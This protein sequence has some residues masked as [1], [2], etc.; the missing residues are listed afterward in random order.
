MN[1]LNGQLPPD[2]DFDEINSQ[3][4]TTMSSKNVEKTTFDKR[5]YLDFTIPNGETSKEIT[6]RLLPISI[7]NGEVEFFK[8]V[9]FHNI[10]V[11][12]ELNPNKSGKKTYM[13]LDS[14]N[15]NIDH[16]IYGSKCPICEAQQELWKQWHNETDE[17][18]KKILIDAIKPLNIREYCIVRCIERGKENEGPKFW[19][20][21]LRQDK[22]DAYHKILLLGETRRKEGLEAGI[23]TNIYSIYEGRDLVIT[24]TEGNGAPTVMDKS[25]STPLTKDENLLISWYYDDKKWDDVFSVK[26]YDYLKIVYEGNVPWFDKENNQWVSKTEFDN[27][28]TTQINK[29][30]SEIAEIENNFINSANNENNIS[31]NETTTNIPECLIDDDLPF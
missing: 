30:D 18:K 25:I 22:T 31:S 3:Q 6:I 15:T 2:V 29:A 19:R 21:P 9:H 16:N 5:N 23:K 11:N 8:I 4:P 10:S 14:K 7:E 17:S 13:C 20:I 1:N 27:L 24:F 12:E 28:K 26:P